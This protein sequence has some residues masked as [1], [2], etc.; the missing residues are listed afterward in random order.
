[1]PYPC[2]ITSTDPVFRIPEDYEISKPYEYPI[3]VDLDFKIVEVIDVDDIK[4]VGIRHMK[5]YRGPH[6]EVILIFQSI[7]FEGEI[8]MRWKDERVSFNNTELA[9]PDGEEE[10]LLDLNVLNQIWTPDVWIES[11]RKFNLLKSY[12]D[13]ASLAINKEFE[14]RWW[15]RYA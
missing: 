6:K 13:Q 8:T 2:R 10:L 3:N 9:F 4:N 7:S 12:E 15:Q 5:R 1:M 11:L 14:I